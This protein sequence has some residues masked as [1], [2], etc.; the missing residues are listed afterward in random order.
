VK[1]TIAAFLVFLL[2]LF[3][4]AEDRLPSPDYH[5]QPSDPAWLAQV[6]QLHGHL[7]PSVVAGARMGMI[8]LRAVG[9]KGYF[10]VEVTCEGPLARPP[11][12][13]FL[14]GIQAATGATMGKRTLNWTQADKLVVRVRNT[15]TGRTVELRP[16]PTLTDL[17]A[18]FKPDA[19]A[20]AGHERGQQGHEHLE[21]IARRI[22][23]LPDKEIASVKATDGQP[24]SAAPGEADRR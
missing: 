8:G 3:A 11:Q 10:D 15:H 4:L 6:V 21:V 23:A 12:S 18:S 19:K 14:D 24:E 22:A 13:C 7:G 16:A 17:L 5:R 20:G 9:A 2:P 1:P